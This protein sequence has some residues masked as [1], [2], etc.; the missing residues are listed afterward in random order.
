MKKTLILLFPLCFL[1]SCEEE[2][3]WS[4][5]TDTTEKLVVEAILTDERKIQEI[6]LSTSFASLNG[7]PRAVDDA[8]IFLRANGQEI[9]FLADSSQKGRYL[10]AAPFRIVG[11]VT[12]ELEI[13]WEN[14]VYQASSVLSSKPILPT[15]R[16][17]E[18]S[19]RSRFFLANVGQ[20]F[21]P[22]EEAL[23][24]VLIDWADQTDSLPNQ[25]LLYFY[26]FSSIHISEFLK[27]NKE[28]VFFPAGSKVIATKYGLN[29]AYGD[30]LRALVIETEWN[31]LFYYSNPENLPTNLS[32]GA[33]GFFSTCAVDVDT[34]IVE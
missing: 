24:E 29:E 2:I 33:L 7:V 19:A 30:F 11:Q 20:V 5:D 14:Q 32:N 13:R 28:R 16:F 22:N 15:L 9:Q 1:L 8:T 18:D 10:S 31:G 26:S 27:P 12:Y 4:L 3:F 34:L 6:K 23:V 17:I 21:N 25:A